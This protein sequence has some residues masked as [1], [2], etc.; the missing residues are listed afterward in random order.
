MGINDLTSKSQSMNLLVQSKPVTWKCKEF[1]GMAVSST[2]FVGKLSSKRKFDGAEATEPYVLL[3]TSGNKKAKIN[4]K[5]G[6][7]L[8]ISEDFQCESTLLGSVV[9]KR[10][11][12]R[13]Q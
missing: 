5:E 9:A 10:Q 8:A 6:I 3:P 12:D 2:G 11:A 13:Q 1:R 7:C 4:K